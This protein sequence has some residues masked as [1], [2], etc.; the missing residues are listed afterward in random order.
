MNP[1]ASANGGTTKRVLAVFL[2]AGVAACA[3]YEDTPVRLA[4]GGPEPVGGMVAAGGS[5]DSAGKAPSAGGAA[6]PSGGSASVS[7]GGKTNSAGETGSGGTATAGTATA[8][9]A[10]AGTATGGTV[11]GPAGGVGGSTRGGGAGAPSGGTAPVMDSCP[12]DPAKAAPGVCGCGFPESDTATLAGCSGLKSALVHRYDF[13][14]TGTVVTD[15]VGTAHGSIKGG[16]TLSQVGGKGAVALGGGSAGA[17]VDLPNGLVSALTNA[18][19]EAWVT[20]GGGDGWQRIFDFGDS[21]NATPEDNPANGKSYLFL[22]P[23]TAA[24]GG[25]MRAVYS[26][27]G[28]AA[29]AETRVEAA[30]MAQALTQVALVVDAA[31]G[32]LILYVDG[33]SVGEQDFAG[34][35]ASINDVNVWLGRSQYSAD[36]EM[37][38][39]FHDFRV[40]EAALTPLQIATSFA[41]GPDPAFLAQ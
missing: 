21:T 12:T 22:T 26:L 17:Y 15:R 23:S 11:G 28:G 10:T 7:V 41:G 37:T 38:G 5:S 16:A 9:T 18:T 27:D 4:E 24:T 1:S 40:Y 39:T 25:V 19:I 8:G 29:A 13:E 2:V 31:G 36:P 3:T 20:W 14:G 34:E 35:L 30:V 33:A 6:V 32:K